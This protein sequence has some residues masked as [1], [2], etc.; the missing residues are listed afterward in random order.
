MPLGRLA[1]L[2]SRLRPNGYFELLPDRLT[3]AGAMARLLA[4]VLPG[5]RRTLDEVV[6]DPSWATRTVTFAG[7]LELVREG[8]LRAYQDDAFGPIEL[9][10]LTVVNAA[11]PSNDDAPAQGGGV[12]QASIA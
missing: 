2:A 8:R 10:G 5:R 4:A 9:E 3:L 12:V 11:V 7:A 6:A 1:E